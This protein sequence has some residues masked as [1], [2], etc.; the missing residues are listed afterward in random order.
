MHKNL[1]H[2]LNTDQVC[3]MGGNTN[4]WAG[5]LLPLLRMI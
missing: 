1:K 3:G 4:I 5:Q 2:K